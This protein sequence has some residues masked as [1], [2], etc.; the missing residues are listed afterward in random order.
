[1]QW[2]E[3][4]HT[5]FDISE[6]TEKDKYHLKIGANYFNRHIDSED[7]KLEYLQNLLNDDKNNK[8][9]CKK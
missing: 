9:R 5:K 1:M 7:K 4:V 8:F 3:I 2:D 6:L